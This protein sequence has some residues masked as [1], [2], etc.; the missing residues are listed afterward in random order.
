[1]EYNN[2]KS[3][4]QC[5]YV[6]DID[7]DCC[8]N[9][10]F[11]FNIDKKCVSCKDNY[12]NEGFK[13]CQSCYISYHKKDKDNRK[14]KNCHEV[15]AYNGFELCKACFI[16][17]DDNICNI[18]KSCN[19]HK[20]NYGYELCN[21][22]YKNSLF[23]KDKNN[24][25]G[26]N[27]KI[28]KVLKHKKCN[29]SAFV[30]PF[31]TYNNETCVWLGLE[32]GGTYKNQ[33]NLIGGK[34]DIYDKVNGNICWCNIAIRNLQE[35]IKLKLRKINNTCPFIIHNNTPIFLIGIKNRISRLLLQ[36]KIDS[37]NVNNNLPPNFKKMSYLAYVNFKKLEICGTI[38]LPISSFATE[39]IKKVSEDD[40]KKLGF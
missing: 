40:L 12:A 23:Y 20:A 21:G 37:D 10:L 7:S 39:V 1:M 5:F 17:S 33:C 14:C 32:N 16:I 8:Y 15:N 13:L 31:M 24:A 18:C 34:G 6:N 26:C 29:N 28:C 19:I 30:L 22:C 27:H 25:V 35:K 36:K 38:Q 9:C 11:I 2:Y 4:P 3:C